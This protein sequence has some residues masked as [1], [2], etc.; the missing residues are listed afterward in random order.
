MR[1]KKV[2]CYWLSEEQ[3]GLFE[4]MSKGIGIVAGYEYRKQVE[5]GEVSNK[6]AEANLK[7]VRD[8]I[9]SALAGK[10]KRRR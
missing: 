1:A 4:S 10:V 3:L 2:N 8:L 5:K 9:D 7:K 6:T